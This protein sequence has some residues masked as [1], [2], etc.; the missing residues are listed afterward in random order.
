MRILITAESE[1]PSF[2]PYNYQ[3]P[4]HSALYSLINE[5]SFEYSSFL[6][7]RG[8]IRDGINKKFKFFTFSKLKFFPTQRSEDGFHNVKKIQFVFA[9]SVNESLKHLVLG[10]F[11]NQRIKF[12]LNGQKSIFDVFNVDIQPEPTFGE[13]GKFICLSPISVTTVR[14]D[15]N[16]KRK[17]HFL[18]YMI[19]EEREHFIE[20]IKKNLVNKYETING[21]KY[22]SLDSS[23][24][25]HFDVDYIS[26][27][28]G[29]ISK[30]INFKNGIK[31]KAIEAPFGVQADPELVKIGY[32][33][34][35]GE[36]NSAGF[37][38]VQKI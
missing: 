3:Y 30:L 21:I 28:K 8:Y 7:D 24:N 15:E 20:N 5:S 32:E 4:L 17:Q 10:I 16:G 34:G 11:S 22:Q 2:F 35:W 26:R 14:I 38:C 13:H 33:C 25:F 19:P 1:K 31:I 6:H 37:G 36:K 29:N 9:S 12:S 18:N 23:F 27:R